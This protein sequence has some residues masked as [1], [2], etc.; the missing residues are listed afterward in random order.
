[1]ARPLIP[2]R[3]SSLLGA[4]P[5]KE[6]DEVKKRK[7]IAAS[8]LSTASSTSEFIEAKIEDTSLSLE[9]F[10]KLRDFLTEAYKDGFLAQQ[11]Y[12]EAMSDVNIT[13]RAGEKE[14]V[15]LKRQKKIV[16]EDLDDEIPSHSKLEDAYAS[17]IT[18]KVMA[19]SG[20]QK[21]KRFDQSH[22]KSDVVQFFKASK[23]VNA[24]E[25]PQVL[26]Y[27]HLSGWHPEKSVKAAHIVPESLQSE[28]ISY[29]FGVGEAVL[30][31]PR[32]CML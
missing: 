25:D 27:C 16:M 12:D 10:Q 9:Y 6:L 18:S 24:D 15:V 4:A 31:N 7:I 11:H 28:E 20:K 1:M 14:M 21:K 19:A 26:L 17:V 3:Y 22:F 8:Q 29:L 5:R 32:N 23:I 13:D 2:E 30:S